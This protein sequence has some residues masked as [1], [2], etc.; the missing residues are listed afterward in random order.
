MREGAKKRERAGKGSERGWTKMSSTS[1]VHTV[2]LSTVSF[3]R[4]GHVKGIPLVYGMYSPLPPFPPPCDPHRVRVRIA[5]SSPFTM[6]HFLNSA[7]VICHFFFPPH[8]HNFPSFSLSVRGGG[9]TGCCFFLL[10]LLLAGFVG[11]RPGVGRTGQPAHRRRRQAT[12]RQRPHR[13]SYRR[14]ERVAQPNVCVG[15][16]MNVSQRRRRFGFVQTAGGGGREGSGGFLAG[17][18]GDGFAG[19]TRRPAGD[20]DAAAAAV[21][22]GDGGLE[23]SFLQLGQLL[24]KKGKE[25]LFLL[26][27]STKIKTR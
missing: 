3:V 19:G 6:L 20:R 22:G 7:T 4:I 23:G 13:R 21:L 9:K 25:F 10:T 12:R 14:Q 18:R 24:K 16:R 1:H 26:F 11:R 8:T 27:F 17:Q 15:V 5:T 2:L